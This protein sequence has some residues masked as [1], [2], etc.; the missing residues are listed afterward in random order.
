MADKLNNKDKNPITD[1]AGVFVSDPKIVKSPADY[2]DYD[3]VHL[4]PLNDLLNDNDQT[5]HKKY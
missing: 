2:G 4:T 3:G 1:F 5:D